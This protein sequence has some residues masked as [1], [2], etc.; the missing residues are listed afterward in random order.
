[1]VF[2]RGEGTHTQDTQRHKTLY[3]P[4]RGFGGAKAKPLLEGCF[5]CLFCLVLSLRKG[6]IP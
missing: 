1:M 6:F 4:E 2:I 3:K 5:A